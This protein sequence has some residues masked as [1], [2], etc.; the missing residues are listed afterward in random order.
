MIVGFTGSSEGMTEE[1]AKALWAWLGLLKKELKI[2]QEEMEF[3]H[4]DCIG[5][6]SDAHD[7]ARICKYKTVAHP[8]INES[9]RAFKKADVILEA[10]QYLARNQD[11]AEVCDVLLAT[12]KEAEEILRSGTW[13]TVRRARKLNKE[14]IIL[15]P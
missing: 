3:H 7:L 4:G 1:Q 5:A 15:S 6:D 2:D 14:V 11:I 12:P 10:K 13:S 9:K 8:P